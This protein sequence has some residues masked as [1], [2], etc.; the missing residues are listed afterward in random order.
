MPTDTERLDAIAS[1]YCII[2]HIINNEYVWVASFGL[3]NETTGATI[4]EALDKC[5]EAVN[6]RLN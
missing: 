1:G 4:R 3:G 6:S 5:I 2:L